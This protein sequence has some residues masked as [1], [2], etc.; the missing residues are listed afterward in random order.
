MLKVGPFKHVVAF[1]IQVLCELP[2][3]VSLCPRTRLAVGN[4]I[5]NRAVHTIEPSL[6]PQPQHHDAS[7]LR[8]F[9]GKRHH[10]IDI[11][12]RI[13]LPVAL[14][15]MQRYLQ[16]VGQCVEQVATLRQQRAVGGYNG[17]EPLPSCHQDE[18]RQQRV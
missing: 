10:L 14:M 8:R 12:F 18:L 4:H 1:Y 17:S 7:A 6:V 9:F 2:S 11:L 3:V 16:L 13:I 15:R 5:Q